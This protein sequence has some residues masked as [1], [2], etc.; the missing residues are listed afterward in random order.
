MD[1]SRLTKRV[2]IWCHDFPDNT[3]CGDVKK[4]SD[5]MNLSTVYHTKGIFNIK[6]IKQA[7]G[8]RV[9]QL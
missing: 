3:Y 2:F 4:I 6:Q 8:H 9:E 7:K 1:N 5:I